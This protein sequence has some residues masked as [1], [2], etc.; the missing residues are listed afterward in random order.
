MPQ[1][2]AYA[3]EYGYSVSFPRMPSIPVTTAAINVGAGLVR[4]STSHTTGSYY[5][6]ATVLSA[7]STPNVGIGIDNGL[8]SVNNVGGQGG[9]VMWVGNGNVNYN[10]TVD[11][12]TISAFSTSD[13]LGVAVNIGS[14]LVWFRDNA[15]NWNNNGAANPAT[16]TGGLSVPAATS[17]T[18][19]VAQLATTGDA[20]QVN[21]AGPFVNTAPSGYG[22]W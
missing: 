18:F 13:V 20:I 19:V 4:S 7:M 11:A 21:F 10:G 16:N 6:E 12:F 8:E 14:G 2:M 5:F 15:G 9:G 3:Q 1:F 17:T 22:N